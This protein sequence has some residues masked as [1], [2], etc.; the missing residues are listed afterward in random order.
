MVG[1]VVVGILD[2]VK[3]AFEMECVAAGETEKVLGFWFRGNGFLVR[4]P[5]FFLF[6]SFVG[7]ESGR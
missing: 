1:I 6:L 7:L 4:N 2:L 5:F 3:E